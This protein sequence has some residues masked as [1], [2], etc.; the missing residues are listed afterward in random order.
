MN[1]DTGPSDVY[2]KED[3][4]K[5]TINDFTPPSSRLLTGDAPEDE[6]AENSVPLVDELQRQS[7][8]NQND[9][10]SQEML[11]AVVHQRVGEPSE[12]G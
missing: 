4:E 10:V 3:Q 8:E 9:R 2:I 12:I 1:N 7:D 6:D 5:I 11:V